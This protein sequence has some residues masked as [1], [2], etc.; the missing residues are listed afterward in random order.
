M[1]NK[2]ADVL[3]K[4]CMRVILSC[5]N[6][7]Q[8]S[9]AIKYCNLAYK[10]LCNELGAVNMTNFASTMERCVDYALCQIKKQ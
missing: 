1:K 2:D 10:I 8:L 4:K 9:N 5:K 3:V 6:D 7:D